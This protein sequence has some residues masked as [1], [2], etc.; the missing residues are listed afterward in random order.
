MRGRWKYWLPL[1]VGAVLLGSIAVVEWRRD[2]PSLPPPSENSAAAPLIRPS[3]SQPVSV[4]AVPLSDA[5]ARA[6]RETELRRTINRALT[7]AVR[8]D[9]PSRR[10]AVASL[11][12]DP[13]T[14]RSAI[15]EMMKKSDNPEFLRQLHLLDRDIQ[16]P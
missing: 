14:A 7:A 13:A 3:E 8:N 11:K 10:A 9:A 5:T 1:G 15:Q 16:A 2:T 12:N 6:A 4:P